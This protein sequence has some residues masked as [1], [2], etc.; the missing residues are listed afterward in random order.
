MQHDYQ[1]KIEK[2]LYWIRYKNL[3]NPCTKQAYTFRILKNRIRESSKRI[4][5][6]LSHTTKGKDDRNEKRKE[7]EEIRDVWKDYTDRVG[8]GGSEASRKLLSGGH[9]EEGGT[10]PLPSH[11]E[12]HPPP[13][14]FVALLLCSQFHYPLPG[15]SST[16][17]TVWKKVVGFSVNLYY[18]LN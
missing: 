12:Q 6:V 1:N 8:E 7:S 18:F 16:S 4:K 13:P 9:L 2:K 15:L 11:L 17:S 14:V 3:R 5:F 10:S